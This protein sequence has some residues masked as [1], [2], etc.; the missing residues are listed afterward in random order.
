MVITDN[1]T[2]ISVMTMGCG[3]D[4]RNSDDEDLPVAVSHSGR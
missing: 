2:T 3:R 1:V 4:A